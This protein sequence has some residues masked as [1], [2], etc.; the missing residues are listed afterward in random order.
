[1][2]R[3]VWAGIGADGLA[4]IIY[5][6]RK[7]AVLAG[8]PLGGAYML[9][10]QAVT[11]IR[12]KVWN[13]AKHACEH[14]GAVVPWHVFELHEFIW[15]GRGGVVSVENGRCLCSDCHHNDPVAGHGDRKLQ[16]T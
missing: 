11:A 8:E 9:R 13:R 12:R 14:C 7:Q 2:A 16:W 6:N 5:K 4:E 10:M 3:M 15:R 1:M